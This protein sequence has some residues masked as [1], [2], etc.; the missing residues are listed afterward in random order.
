MCP[1]T[2]R[3]GACSPRKRLRRCAV[4]GVGV[5]IRKRVDRDRDRD[6]RLAL[7][8]EQHAGAEKFLLFTV[9]TRSARRTD[10]DLTVDD[11]LPRQELLDRQVDVNTVG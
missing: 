7:E 11:Q 9:T 5:W 8:S 4:S 10:D 1:R 6:L 2:I 3:S